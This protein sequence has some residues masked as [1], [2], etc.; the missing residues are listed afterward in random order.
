M[1][2]KIKIEGLVD[3]EGAE[4][5]CICGVCGEKSGDKAQIEFNFREQKVFFLCG[6]KECRKMN[7]MQFGKEKPT[8]YPRSYVSR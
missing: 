1:A 5:H 4:F 2:K 7:E 3:I 6:N 8:P